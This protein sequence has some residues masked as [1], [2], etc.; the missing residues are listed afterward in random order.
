MGKDA[1][2]SD[3]VG[4]DI[5]TSKVCAL[6]AGEREGEL[7]L[8]GYGTAVSAGMRKG[9]IINLEATEKAI[10]AAVEEAELMAGFGVER[11]YVGVGG[12]HIKGFN[13]RGSITL[14]EGHPKITRGDIARVIAAARAVAIPN[15]QEVIHLLPQEFVVDDDHGVHD[16][17]GMSG[18]RLE[19]GVHLVTGSATSVRNVVA[20]AQGAGIEVSDTV[21][22]QL[23]ASLATLSDDEKELGVAL[24]DLGGGTTD[25]AIHLDGSLWHTAVLPIGGDHI[26]SDIAVGL[27]TP[28][29]EADTIKI[30]HGAAVASAAEGE[31]AIEV[32]TIG[33]GRTRV[34]DRSA[35]IEIVNARVEEIFRLVLDEM[36]RVGVMQRLNAGVALTGGSA[37]LPGIVD[38]AEQVFELP[39][40]TAVPTGFAGIV[41]A[42]AQPEYSVA[43]GLVRFGYDN[44]RSPADNS[45]PRAGLMGRLRRKFKD[46]F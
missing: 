43:A 5:G 22:Q 20:C 19:V 15:D 17:L 34:V 28:I 31:G 38:L 1:K 7:T 40:R 46:I 6:I 42:I 8:L 39:A 41:D 16:P 9:A 33:E 13:S 45:F 10:A 24:L 12:G 37:K 44:S 21:L 4:L 2:Q 26:T 23:A 32:T 11:A 29:P 35:L 27:R 36:R 3:I 14:P 18:H 30:E 25:M